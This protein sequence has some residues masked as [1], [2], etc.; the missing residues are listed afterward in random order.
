MADAEW[1][2]LNERVVNDDALRTRLVEMRGG[3]R[4]CICP[5]CHACVEPLDI[6]EAERLGLLP[7]P[8][9]EPDFSAITR[10]FCE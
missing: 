5:P 10:A 6:G 8:T 3:C 4:C 9:K 2:E 1:E 7:E